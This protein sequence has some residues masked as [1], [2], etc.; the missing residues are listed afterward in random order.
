MGENSKISWCDHTVNFWQGCKKVSPGC[1]NCYMFRD[2]KRFGQD[3]TKIIRSKPAT[4]RS[5][6]KYKPGDKIFVCSWSDFFIEE[7][8]EWRDDAWDIIRK[9]PHLIYQILTKRPEN[10]KDRLPHDWPLENVWLG[11]TAENQDMADLRIPILLSTQ[12][13]LR[14]VSIEPMVGPVDLERIMAKMPH[15]GKSMWNS[16]TSPC[17]NE[18]DWV[19]C[20][21][22]TGPNSREMSPL[23]ALSLKE[24]CAMN[25][26]PFF[27]KQMTN[28]KPIPES[29]QGR[30]FPR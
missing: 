9:T 16:L 23:W 12:A 5:S 3:P 26:T 15:G 17:F 8:D 1:L 7:A 13:V 4:F 2:K 22:E 11:V 14:F 6:L 24:Q 30:E 21:G 29:L 20:G 27:M 28:K 18:I 10:I 25:D 19:I